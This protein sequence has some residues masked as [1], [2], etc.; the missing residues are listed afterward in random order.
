LKSL[1]HELETSL[2]R[3]CVTVLREAVADDVE[4][5]ADSPVLESDEGSALPPGM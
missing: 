4:L 2:N 3:L 5:I 1:A